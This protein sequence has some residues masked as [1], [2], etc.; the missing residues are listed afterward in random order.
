MKDDECAIFETKAIPSLTFD[1]L[2]GSNHF[3]ASKY[4]RTHNVWYKTPA[5]K[6]NWSK[7]MQIG[8][9]IRVVVTTF[10][11]QL[12]MIMRQPEIFH[13]IRSKHHSYDCII[14]IH[15]KTNT[16]P[17]NLII[18][19]FQWNLQL[20]RIRRTMPVQKGII[21]LSHPFS[22]SSKT[23]FTWTSKKKLCFRKAHICVLDRCD[24]CHRLPVCTRVMSHVNC[25]W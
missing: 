24:V 21:N 5:E 14:V 11:T 15:P 2:R 19:H 1:R 16:I 6:A 25:N 8:Y 17:F 22:T 23:C 10:N 12:S 13:L 3:Y 7:S 9:W 18:K 4:A 20:N